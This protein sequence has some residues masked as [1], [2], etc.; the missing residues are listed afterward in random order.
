[1]SMSEIC[2]EHFDEISHICMKCVQEVCVKCVVLDHADH[3]DKVEEYQVGIENLKSNLEETKKKL[4]RRQT[5]I[6]KCQNELDSKKKDASKHKKELQRRRDALIK[7]IEQIDNELLDVCETER[8]CDEDVKM[9]KEFKEKF[10]VNYRDVDKLS[11]SPQNQ[12]VSNF[13]RQSMSVEK[14]LKETEKINNKFNLDI[15]EEV[16]WLK[17]PVVENSFNNLGNFQTEWPTSIRAVGHDLFVYS[18]CGTNR[19]VVFDNKGVVIRNFEGL[20]EH[21]DVRCVDVYK[22]NLYLAQERQILCLSNFNTAKE[23]SFTFMPKIKS[24]YGMAVASDNILICTDCDYEGE[25][26]EYN[27][28]DDTTKLVLQG[29]GSPTNV[30]VDHTPAGTRYILTLDNTCEFSNDGCVQIYNGFWQLLTT[31]TQGDPCDTAPCPGGFL[32]AD[33]SSN[34]I[35]L[36]S[37]KGHLVRTVLTEEDDDLNYPIC[38]VLNP[39]YLWLG[40]RSG[41]DSKLTCFRIFQ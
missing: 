40:H 29:L 37:Y 33:W 10:D 38:L 9:C 16:Q 36:Y 1:M 39:P 13:L 2:Q 23:R 31:I 35:T 41:G 3:E 11:Q 12:T 25:V 20:K 19:F 30:S 28:D 4:K 26:Y 17:K 14:I 18:D 27:T 7:E 21:G 5:A 32:L 24:L 34:K 22:D 8:K 15:H 6:T